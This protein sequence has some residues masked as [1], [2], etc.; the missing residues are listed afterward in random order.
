[1]L[2]MMGIDPRS[3]AAARLRTLL[4]PSARERLGIHS[5]A[6]LVDYLA[7]IQAPG[8]G[9]DGR[10]PQVAALADELRGVL[11]SLQSWA[12]HDFTRAIFD[13][14]LP[15]P[16]LAALDVSIWLTGSLDLPT[17]EEM[18]TPHLHNNLSERKLASVAIYGMLVRLARLAFFA[19]RE[20]FGLIVLE[21]AGA[22][23]NSRAG[24]DDAHLISR[25]ARKHFTGLC[26][27]TQDPVA[28]LALM[29]DQFITQQ[30]IMPFEDETLARKVVTLAGIRLEDYPDIEEYFLAQPAV[31]QM[32]DPTAFDAEDH[33]LGP[34]TTPHRGDREGYGF[35]VDEFRRPAPIRVIRQP[36]PAIH[37][38][39]DTTPGAA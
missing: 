33:I 1:M 30:L 5:T 12:T 37:A 17:A 31:E 38:A 15:I 36:D 19:N 21:E 3:V 23:L 9:I 32:R 18:A 10:P 34:D 39:F 4:S 24:A 6:A 7:S 8:S 27:I 26:L 13:P 16:D 20:R 28:D 35:F 11:V 22:L 14:T 25:R 2:P 29:G